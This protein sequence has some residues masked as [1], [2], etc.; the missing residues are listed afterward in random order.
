VKSQYDIAIARLDTTETKLRLFE[1]ENATSFLE[2]QRASLD[3][4]TISTYHKIVSIGEQVEQMDLK[5]Q[6]INLQLLSG[7]SS[8]YAQLKQDR[9]QSSFENILLVQAHFDR[10]LKASLLH[11]DMKNNVSTIRQ[12]LE[13]DGIDSLRLKI[14]HLEKELKNHEPVIGGVLNPTF[15][16]LSNQLSAV[17]LKY[18]STD[19]IDA[20]STTHVDNTDESIRLDN[21]RAIF[22]RRELIINQHDISSNNYTK[23]LVQ[24]DSITTQKNVLARKKEYYNGQMS[25]IK[26]S[27]DNIKKELSSKMQ[28]QQR[29]LRDRDLLSGTVTRFSKLFEEARIVR[30]KAAGDI[31][32]LTR[33]LEV[34]QV[35]QEQGQQKA[36]IAAGVGFLLSSILSLFAEY[37]RKARQNRA[38]GTNE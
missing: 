2:I 6:E 32:V 3:T 31:R 11:Y 9:Q 34:R 33:A 21:A 28:D 26:S 8:L 27:L 36:A 10:Q 16:E 14:G 35:S 15:I 4:A 7:D 37:M 29:L 18:E 13:F 17:R 5:L 22:Q 25:S 19:L 20:D 23:A 12:Q 30:E 24:R 38:A 1:A